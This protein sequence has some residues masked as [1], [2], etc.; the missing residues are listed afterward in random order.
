[1]WRNF[2]T[3]H[4]FSPQP[5]VVMVVTNIRYGDGYIEVFAEVEEVAEA[6]VPG[7]LGAA[8]AP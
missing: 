7:W 5:A 3:W 6:G 8:S 2:S 4:I 1:M